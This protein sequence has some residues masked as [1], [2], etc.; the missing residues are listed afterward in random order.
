MIELT[1]R[2]FLRGT[3]GVVG[4]ML[5]TRIPSF[6]PTVFLD[7]VHDDGPGLNALFRGDPVAI[8]NEAALMRPSVH[9]V[10][11]QKALIR[12]RETIVLPAKGPDVTMN[13]CHVDATGLTEGAALYLEAPI[14]IHGQPVMPGRECP[15]LQ[16]VYIEGRDSYRDRGRPNVFTA[17]AVS[18]TP[19]AE[20]PDSSL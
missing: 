5:L 20:R 6:L 7:G 13:E 9:E 14:R 3:L 8:L 12:T 16:D 15:V 17:R 18:G 1:R 10:I 4:G 2:R 11:L 19:C